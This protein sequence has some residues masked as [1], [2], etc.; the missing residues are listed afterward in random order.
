MSGLAGP[1]CDRDTICAIVGGLVA[2]SAAPGTI[3]RDWADSVEAIESP[4]VSP[5]GQA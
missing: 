4:L 5:A 2:V 1:S 3:P